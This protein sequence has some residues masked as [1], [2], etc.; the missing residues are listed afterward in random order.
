[1]IRADHINSTALYGFHPDFVREENDETPIHEE[2]L[3]GV[4]AFDKSDAKW[5]GVF[6]VLVLALMLVL[7][8]H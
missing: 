7:I 4:Y 6:L 3:E 1:M 8:L 5:S 2:E